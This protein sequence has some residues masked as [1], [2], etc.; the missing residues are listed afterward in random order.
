MVAGCGLLEDCELEELGCRVDG[1]G[2]GL[3]GDAI[4]SNHNAVTETAASPTMV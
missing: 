1:L 3:G 4:F 2:C